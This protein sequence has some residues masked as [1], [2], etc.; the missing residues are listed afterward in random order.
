MLHFLSFFML[1]LVLPLV[2]PMATPARDL[3]VRQSGDLEKRFDN[4]QWSHYDA[5]KWV[6]FCF[7]STIFLDH[8]FSRGSCGSSS[9]ASDFVSGSFKSRSHR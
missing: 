4:T 3:A 6:D 7:S 1:F 2:T 5:G 8:S 9:A